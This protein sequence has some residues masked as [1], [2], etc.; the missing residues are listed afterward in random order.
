MCTLIAYPILAEDSHC[1]SDSCLRCVSL[2]LAE[3]K[4]HTAIFLNIMNVLWLPCMCKDYVKIS[5][6]SIPTQRFISGFCWRPS[7]AKDCGDSYA[8]SKSWRWKEWNNFNWTNDYEF[9]TIRYVHIS[10]FPC[11]SCVAVFCSFMR[12]LPRVRLHVSPHICVFR[13]VH[14]IIQT[15]LEDAWEAWLSRITILWFKIDHD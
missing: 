6:E 11:I 12:V 10:H 14:W 4:C 8:L 1:L 9:L 15:S 5:L 3:C 2:I 7:E 13:A